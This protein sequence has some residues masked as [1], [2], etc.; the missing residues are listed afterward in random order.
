VRRRPFLRGAGV[1]VFAL[2]VAFPAAAQEASPAAAAPDLTV[3][4]ALCT[5]EPRPLEEFLAAVGSPAPR[6]AGEESSVSR[7]AE[8]GTGVTLPE[9]QPADADQ[10]AGVTDTIYGFFAC[11]NAGDTLRAISRL[12]DDFVASQIGLSFYDEDFIELL[13]ASPVPVAESDQTLLFGIRDVTTYPDGRVGALID[14]FSPAAPTESE[15]GYETDLFIFEQVASGAW[16][17]D[18]VVENLE[19]LYPPSFPGLVAH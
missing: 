2:L 1:A 3:D 12:T 9:G 8:P 13:Q 16:H 15:L 4:P 7:A 10:V 11:N 18:E 5:N 19:A 14:Y 17:L 6:G